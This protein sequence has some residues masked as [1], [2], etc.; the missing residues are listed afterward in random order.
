MLKKHSQIVLVDVGLKGL[1]P[2]LCCV[3]VCGFVSGRPGHWDPY[4]LFLI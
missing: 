4:V 3:A 1:T 2:M